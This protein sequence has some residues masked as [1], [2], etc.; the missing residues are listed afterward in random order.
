MAPPSEVGTDTLLPDLPKGPLQAYRARASF[1]WQELALFLEGED[2]LRLK[3]RR[4]GSG[5]GWAPRLC[6]VFGSWARADRLTPE[7]PS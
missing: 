4:A 6:W 1:C 3:V 2:V 7:G 5:P